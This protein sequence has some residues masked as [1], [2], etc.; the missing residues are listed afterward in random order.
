M[1]SYEDRFDKIR[2]VFHGLYFENEVDDPPIF[3]CISYVGNS[4][5]DCS[6][7]MKSICVLEDYRTNVLKGQHP[8]LLA[9]SIRK[10]TVML[11]RL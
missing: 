2:V 10:E 7:S 4:L 9:L 8:L 1:S 5:S 3:F 11:G 6:K